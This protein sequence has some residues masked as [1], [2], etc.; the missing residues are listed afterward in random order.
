ML[1]RKV[2]RPSNS[3][4]AAPI[5]LADKKGGKV[6]FCIDYHRL[7]DVTK[8]DAYPLP[9]MDEILAHLGGSK[10][11]SLMDLSDAFWSIPVKEEHIKKTVFITKFSLWE[12]ISMPVGLT[13]APPTQQHYMEKVFAGLIYTCCFVYRQYSNI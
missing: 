12:F 10:Y 7:N 3:H 1:K 4:R 5:L 8:K 9:Q 13:N 11:F 6:C 2:I